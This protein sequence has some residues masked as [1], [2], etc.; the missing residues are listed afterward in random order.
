MLPTPLKHKPLHRI[1]GALKIFSALK[2]SDILRIY[3]KAVEGKMIT[4]L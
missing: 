2:A 3:H 4:E 1:I